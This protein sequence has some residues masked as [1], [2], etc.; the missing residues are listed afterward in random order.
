MENRGTKEQPNILQING[1]CTK[2]IT[3]IL[4]EKSK[5]T[6]NPG[7]HGESHAIVNINPRGTRIMQGVLREN[8]RLIVKD[9]KIIGA[10]ITKVRISHE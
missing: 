10:D 9:R 5:N 2:E 8:P 1:V 3:E 6:K 4:L 7:L